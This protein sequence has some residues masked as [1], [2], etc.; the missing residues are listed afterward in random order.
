MKATA[1]HGFAAVAILVL[2]SS[3]VVPTQARADATT[4]NPDGS[5][6][7]TRNVVFESNNTGGSAGAWGTEAKCPDGGAVNT[8]CGSGANADCMGSPVQVACAATAQ[9]AVYKPGP[10]VSPVYFSDTVIA[11]NW[12]QRITC[13]DGTPGNAGAVVA[14]CGSG[15][16]MDCGGKPNYVRCA[17]LLYG[18]GGDTMINCDADNCPDSVVTTSN[19]QWVSVSE[20]GGWAVCPDGMVATGF[21]GSGANKDCNGNVIELQCSTVSVQLHFDRGLPK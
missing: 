13:G 12:G 2:F 15:G 9:A 5:A 4:V 18:D 3:V 10:L 6:D 17:A 21:C 1:R 7:I 16:N 14:I 8:A 20:W 11:D 19:P